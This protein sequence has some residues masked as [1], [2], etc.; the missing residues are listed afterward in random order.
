MKVYYKQSFIV[1]TLGILLGCSSTEEADSGPTSETVSRHSDCISKGSIRDYRVLDDSN[2]IVTAGASRRY[3]VALSRKAFGLRSTLGIA[4][5]SSSGRVCG[6][7]D[8][9]IVDDAFGPESIRIAAIRRLTPEQEN[10]LLVRFGLRE[11][12]YEQP[13]QPEKVEG[14]E[15][16]E[17][18]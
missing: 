16:E 3:H 12:E 14:A 9:L 8:R 18:D 2:L 11:P 6:G 5:E 17:L 7:F 10:D 1:I 15:V 13:R 4:F